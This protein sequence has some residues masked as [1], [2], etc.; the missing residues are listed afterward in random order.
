MT[1]TTNNSLAAPLTPQTLAFGLGWPKPQLHVSKMILVLA[2]VHQ[3][4]GP[5]TTQNPHLS[6]TDTWSG[7]GSHYVPVTV[8]KVPQG[9]QLTSYGSP[10]P[11]L[12]CPWD[13]DPKPLP[14]PC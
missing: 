1:G 12:G 3:L 6:D 9:G 14:S 7:H 4:P 2:S 8:N 13:P 11:S 10:D 5:H